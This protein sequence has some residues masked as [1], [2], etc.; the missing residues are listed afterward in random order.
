MKSILTKITPVLI[1]DSIEESLPLWR[2]QLGYK[3]ETEV[4]H[5]GRLGFVILKQGALEL[6]LQTKASIGGDLPA[7]LKG[8]AHTQS[9]LLY[10]D[11]EDLDKTISG[12]SG[13]EILVPKRK[14]FYG[15]HEVWILTDSG[16]V[17]GL[18]QF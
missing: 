2:D 18:A 4:P 8:K 12:L 13:A 9:V 10:A 3:I 16:H 17:L 14:T 7:L 5:E 11:V 6:M 15:A 1:V